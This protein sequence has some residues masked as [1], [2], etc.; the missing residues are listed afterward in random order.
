MNE[1]A[2]RQN[3]WVWMAVRGWKQSCCMSPGQVGLDDL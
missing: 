3:E 1:H 2:K